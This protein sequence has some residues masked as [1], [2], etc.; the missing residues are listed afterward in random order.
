MFS[1]DFE[2]FLWA[3]GYEQPQIDGLLQKMRDVIPLTDVEFTAMSGLFKDYMIVGGMPAVVREY[4]ESNTFSGI[5]TLQKQLL[6][7]YQEDITKYADGL[8]K[9]RI[10][11]V[12]NHISTFLAKDY[13]KFQISKVARNARSRDY[14]GVVDWL[15]SAG[16][17][18]VC[19]C[20]D[21]LELP[22]KG[23]YNP[24]F[25][26][27]YYQ[28]TGLLVGS[29]NEEAQEDLRRNR[30]FNTYKGALYENIVADMLRKSGYDLYYYRNEKSTIELD[31]IV[32]DSN[33][34]IPL[35]VKAD[36]GA[37]KSLSKVTDGRISDIYYGIKFSHQNIGFNG[38]IYTFPYFLCFLLRPFLSSHCQMTNWNRSK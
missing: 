33:S 31:F 1:L 14:V 21:S 7:D 37:S 30:N 29:L 18:N 23:N 15:A 8:D 28:D 11:N 35:E 36:H 38:H 25:F 10:L 22:M 27:L 24:D 6:L 12:Y 32:R 3:K 19:Y 2:E 9:G 4:I 20:M 5:L 17:V 13:K 34:L 16:I 26:K